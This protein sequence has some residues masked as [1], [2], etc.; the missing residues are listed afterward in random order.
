MYRKIWFAMV[1]GVK[2]GA[3]AYLIVLATQLQPTPVTPSNIVSMLIMS[4][5]IGLVSLIFKTDY[6]SL[7]VSGLL[8]FTGV[9]VVVILG[10]LYNGWDVLAVPF[11]LN[12]IGMYIVIWIVVLINNA[13]RTRKINDRLSELRKKKEEA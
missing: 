7:L 6:F 10:M 13:I 11:W 9:S 8:H 5:F 3:V 12:F 1:E 2:V 4:A